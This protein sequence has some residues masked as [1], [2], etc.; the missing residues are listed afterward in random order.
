MFLEKSNPLKLLFYPQ[1]SKIS[2]N[3]NLSGSSFMPAATNFILT[4]K[5]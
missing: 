1:H 4:V 3:N 5:R 2:K